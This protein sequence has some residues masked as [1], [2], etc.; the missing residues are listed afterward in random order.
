MVSLFSRLAFSL[1]TPTTTNYNALLFFA[2]PSTRFSLFLA[3]PRP[4]FR[5]SVVPYTCG[6][7]YLACIRVYVCVRA[8][9]LATV[10]PFLPLTL[11]LSRDMYGFTQTL[12][13]GGRVQI[14]STPV[15]TLSMH[16]EFFFFFTCSSLFCL[17]FL[18]FFF[19]YYYLNF[20]ILT[21]SL[22]L[23]E[24]DSF[25][26]LSQCVFFNSLFFVSLVC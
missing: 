13:S 15:F 11:P 9:S 6:R 25:V 7:A 14:F 18:F 22:N 12:H 1:A 16:L 10:S 2:S 4:R 19:F 26:P 17:P 21:P 3:P 24:S 5:L 8:R 23:R 20:E